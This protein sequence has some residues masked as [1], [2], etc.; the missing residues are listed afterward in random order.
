MANG[1][2]CSVGRYAQVVQFIECNTTAMTNLK[3]PCV[4][5]ESATNNKKTY[6]KKQKVTRKK[7]YSHRLGCNEACV[8]PYKLLTINRTYKNNFDERK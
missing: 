6:K 4:A 8:I 3:I 5:P 2:F 7:C 1:N